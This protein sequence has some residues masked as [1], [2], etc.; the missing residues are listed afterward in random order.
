MNDLLLG[1]VGALVATNQPLAVSNLIQQ[2]SGIT[3]QIPNPDDPIESELRQIMIADDA[4][5]DDIDHTIQTNNV[6]VAQGKG[7]PKDELNRQIHARIDVISGKYHEFIDRHPNYA[8]GYMAYG[9]FLDQTGDEE[10]AKT[11]YENARQIDPKDP[12][13]WNNLANFYGEY[14]PVTNAFAYYE[15]AMRLNPAEPVYIHNLA[16]TVYLFRPD[17]ERFYHINEQ[18]VFDKSIDLYHQAMKLAPKDFLLASDLAENYYGIKP[19]RTNDALVAWTNAYNVAS[20]EAEREGIDIHFARVNWL[21]GRYADA[22]S[23]LDAVTNSNYGAVKARLERNI[24]KSEHPESNQVDK[25]TSP[26][27]LATISTAGTNLA[28]LGTNQPPVDPP[29]ADKK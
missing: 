16:V 2:Q 12:A 28:T 22:Q 9:S 1:L 10:A 4:T 26:Q 7:V 5:M 23:Y 11:Q 6:M 8:R 14:G 25:E 17:A 29:P 20:T 15:Q 18:Q 24:V 21:I 13:A 27:T 3:V 19:F